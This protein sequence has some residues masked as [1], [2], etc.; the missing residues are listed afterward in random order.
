[1]QA[2]FCLHLIFITSYLPANAWFF[3]RSGYQSPSS[4]GTRTSYAVLAFVKPSFPTTSSSTFFPKLSAFC[5]R[6]SKQRIQPTSSHSRCGTPTRLIV[7]LMLSASW[8]TW[9]HTVTSY[10]LIRGYLST[11][12][13]KINDFRTDLYY[14]SIQMPKINKNMSEKK[15]VWGNHLSYDIK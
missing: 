7:A 9:L 10:R 3:N 11:Y 14:F 13:W 5:S 12:V 1:M 4:G 15:D 8:K 2:S 6:W